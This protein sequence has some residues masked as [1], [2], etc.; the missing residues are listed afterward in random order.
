VSLIQQID[1]D[2]ATSMKG[3]EVTRTGVLRLLKTSF[4]NEQIKLGHELSGE[5]LTKVVQREAKQRRDSITQYQAA[6]RDDLVKVEQAELAIIAEYLPKQ[7]D[8]EELG[9]II[10]AIISETGA[11]GMAQM[12]QVIG[13]TVKKVAGAADGATI[14]KLVKA[15]LQ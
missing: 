13:A 9:K 8:E 4:K 10:D 15:R 11:T 5:E 2:L 3:G 6:N 14:S 1:S 7:M 12:G